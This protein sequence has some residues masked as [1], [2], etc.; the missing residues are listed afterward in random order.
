M[1]NI[2]NRTLV[3]L[4]PKHNQERTIREYKPISCCTIVY[5][6]ISKVMA[7]RL[8]RVLSNIISRS[9]AAFVPGQ[10]IHDHVFLAYELIR[11]YN[12]KG[13]MPRCMLQMD[14]Q[15]DYDSVDWHALKMI[16][17]EVRCPRL[18]IKWIMEV[19]TTVS[20][21]FNVNGRNTKVMIDKRG[22]RQGDP[23]SP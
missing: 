1:D 4:I 12:G 23:I 15:K 17:G 16:L 22:L 21:Q 10:K 19:V 7:T 3:T 9:Q 2:F 8:S 20:Y 14:V 13:G 6:I 18:F 5:K 11:S